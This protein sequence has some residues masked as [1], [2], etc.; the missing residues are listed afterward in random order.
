MKHLVPIVIILFCSISAS[1]Q[2]GATTET[3]A[4]AILDYA[5]GS[6]CRYYCTDERRD[7]APDR[8]D[9]VVSLKD[10]ARIG[11]AILEHPDIPVYIFLGTAAHESSFQ[12]Y[13]IGGGGEA[14]IFQQNAE[15][16]TEGLA[17]KSGCTGRNE[18]TYEQL[19]AIRDALQ[20]PYIAVQV[21]AW[22]YRRQY[23]RFG[24]YW[25]AAYNQ[26]ASTVHR[27]GNHWTCNSD[28]RDYMETNHRFESLLFTLVEQ[29]AADVEAAAA[30]SKG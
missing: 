17:L 1:A 27:Q 11:D 3:I 19:E 12:R 23:D 8:S 21:F 5:D 18:C 22:Q 29:A 13:A 4:Q 9:Y 30:L 6:I 7:G 2:D 24:D 10:A 28:G 15:F 16:V 20:D 26:G 25:A 14:G